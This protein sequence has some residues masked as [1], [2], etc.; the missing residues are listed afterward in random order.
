M[1]ND[2][3]AS[4]R[5]MDS[6]GKSFEPGEGRQNRGRGGVMPFRGAVSI[7]NLTMPTKRVEWRWGEAVEY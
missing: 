1:Q 7:T 5:S 3:P 6:G 4:K 2:G